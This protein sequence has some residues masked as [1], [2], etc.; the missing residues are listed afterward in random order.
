MAQALFESLTDLHT[1]ASAGL[2][3]FDGQPASE[4]AV[5]VMDELGI[6]LSDHRSNIITAQDQEQY[7]LFFAMSQ[8]H[9]NALIDLGIPYDKIKTPERDIADPYGGSLDDYRA[10]RDQIK[11]EIEAWLGEL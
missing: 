7:D 9:K 10:A 4:P 2:A 5:T 11:K 3:A 6:D 8:N 1:C